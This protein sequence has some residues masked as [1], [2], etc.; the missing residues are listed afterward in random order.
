MSNKIQALRGIQENQTVLL[1]EVDNQSIQD[2]EVSLTLDYKNG[3][4]KRPS[5]WQ[6]YM[7]KFP[8]SKVTVPISAG[9]ILKCAKEQGVDAFTHDDES[10]EYTLVETRFGIEDGNIVFGKSE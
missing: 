4:T 7:V 9:L 5:E 1:S 6:G 2:T 3:A 8:E 10:D